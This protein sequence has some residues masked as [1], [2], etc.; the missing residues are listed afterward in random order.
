MIRRGVCPHVFVIG[1]NMRICHAGRGADDTVGSDPETLSKVML[2]FDDIMKEAGGWWV[3]ISELVT[4]PVID[5][6][7]YQTFQN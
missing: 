6:Q 3:C 7:E 5:A 2:V 1:W 4:R